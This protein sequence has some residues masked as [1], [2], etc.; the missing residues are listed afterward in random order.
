MKI[1]DLPKFIQPQ[2]KLMKYGV[3]RLTNDELLAIIIGSGTHSMNAISLAHF[4]RKKEEFTFDKLRNIHGLG[5]T[6]IARI[7]AS[8]EYGKRMQQKTNNAILSP[9]DLWNILSDVRVSKKE[10]FVVFYLDVQNQL[11]QKETISIGTLNTSIVHPREVYEPAI[12]Y[13]AAQI[14]MSHNHPSGVCR[15]SNEDLELTQQIKKAGE[16][17]G[18]EL[19]DHVIVTKEKYY[20]FREKGIL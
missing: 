13:S 20:S 4:I 11:I 16:I 2:E 6:K 14:I 7:L 9:K 5:K 12:R 10:Y 8:I 17:L 19:A 18:I 3:G 1:K 15:P